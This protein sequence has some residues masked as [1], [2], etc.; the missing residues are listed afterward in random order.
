MKTKYTKRLLFVLVILI[1]VSMVGFILSGA[2]D[3]TVE[4]EPEEPERTILHTLDWQMHGTVLTVDGKV[5][6]EVE[7]SV[8]G[9]IWKKETSGVYGDLD[10]IFPESLKTRFERTLTP[11]PDVAYHYFEFGYYMFSPFIFIKDCDIRNPDGECGVDP[12][13]GYFIFFWPDLDQYLVGS[14]DPDV[15]AAEVF[16]HF[17]KF[18]VFHETCAEYSK[19]NLPWEAPIDALMPAEKVEEKLAQYYESIADPVE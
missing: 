9:E 4:V 13:K 8:T 14:L 7:F 15:E 3:P 19:D 11:L 12:E 6:D 10:I 2:A 18:R 1:S 16:A 5:L 17:V